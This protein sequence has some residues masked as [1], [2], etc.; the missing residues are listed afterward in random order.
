[1]AG[2]RLTVMDMQ[3]LGIDRVLRAA[4][5]EGQK[6]FCRSST[7]SAEL[8]TFCGQVAGRYCPS[9]RNSV[10][11]GCLTNVLFALLFQKAAPQ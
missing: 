1:M 2:A 4:R 6:A 11:S 3:N 10:G 7:R 5:D 9:F 8:C